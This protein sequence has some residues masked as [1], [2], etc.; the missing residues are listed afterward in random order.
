MVEEGFQNEDLQAVRA[1][2]AK[3]EATRRRRQIA[4]R[5]A[6]DAKPTV[7]GERETSPFVT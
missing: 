5:E 1:G 6:K 4:T 2:E 7:A 3:A